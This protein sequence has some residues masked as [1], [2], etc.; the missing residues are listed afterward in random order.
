MIRSAF[1]SDLNQSTVGTAVV[2]VE[3]DW[4][5]VQRRPA[6]G[7]TLELILPCAALGS[8]GRL[9]KFITLDH[10]INGPEADL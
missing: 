2:K 6:S 7:T 1:S 3:W 10:V 5:R 8:G 9:P 4:G